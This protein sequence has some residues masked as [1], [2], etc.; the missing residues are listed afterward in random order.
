MENRQDFGSRLRAQRKKIKLTTE[1]LAKLAA[2]DR[3]YITKIERHNKLPSLAIMQTICDKL[4][5]RD[6]F[7]KYLKIKYPLMYKKWREEEITREAGW[8]AHEFRQIKED[9]A[10]IKGKE[11]PPEELR[12]LKK[13]I[14]FFGNDVNR[15]VALLYGWLEEIGKIEKSYP[16]LKNIPHQKEKSKD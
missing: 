8:L 16:N 10:K 7:E 5:D 9:I 13:R 14:L 15:S 2:I 12:S 3:T 6:L 4:H 1:Q 11:I